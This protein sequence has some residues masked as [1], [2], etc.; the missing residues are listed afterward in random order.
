[1]S[2]Y[3]VSLSLMHPER[4]EAAALANED[5]RLSHPSR[6]TSASENYGT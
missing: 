1:M 6:A 5:A 3:S 4:L 2:T